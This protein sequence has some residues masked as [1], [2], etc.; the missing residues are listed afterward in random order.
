MS[1]QFSLLSMMDTDLYE[2]ILGLRAPWQVDDVTLVRP[3]AQ[4]TVHVSASEDAEWV[5]P[6]GGGAASGYDHRVRKWRHLCA[7]QYH[8]MLEAKVPRVRCPEHGVLTV[9]LPWSEPDSGSTAL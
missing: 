8:T 3:A 5:C 7:M 6:H 9:N 1:E 4:V 2:Q